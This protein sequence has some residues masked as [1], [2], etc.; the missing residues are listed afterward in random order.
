MSYSASNLQLLANN[1]LTLSITNP[2]R[3]L[4]NADSSVSSTS[5]KITIPTQL[6]CSAVTNN[7]LTIVWNTGVI[8]SLP[9]STGTTTNLSVSL[10]T[11]YVSYF[12]GTINYHLSETY[13]NITSTHTSI[14]IVNICGDGC[15]Q[16]SGTICTACFNT[17]WAN[18]SLLYNGVCYQNC[19]V[20][21]FQT[22]GACTDC[23]PSCSSCTSSA[24]NN[25]TSCAPAFLNNT[26]YCLSVCGQGKYLSGSICLLCDLECTACISSTNCYV[27]KTNATMIGSTCD[28]TSCFSPCL[29]CSGVQSNC[30]ACISSY[31]LYQFTCV[32]A[33]PSGTYQ[34]TS[35]GQS[36]CI[37]IP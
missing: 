3:N 10:G 31:S 24:Y 26:N 21:T 35:N 11:C 36:V 12:T 8:T 14:S 33:C 27:C 25:C 2:Y 34:S 1:T 19:P 16:C 22:T 28:F 17:T 13:S 15:Y 32:G 6:N 9:T 29:T 30:T 37:T 7:S 18:L 4:T 5:L 20:N 23:H